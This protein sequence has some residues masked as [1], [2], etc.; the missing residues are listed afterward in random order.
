MDG[1]WELKE[2]G[3]ILGHK[4]TFEGDEYVDCGDGF[5]GAYIW[6]N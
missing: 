5:T 2:G 1:K 4:N 3:I 6:Q